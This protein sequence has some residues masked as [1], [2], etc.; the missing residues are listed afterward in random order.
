[1][2][3]PTRSTLTSVLRTGGAVAAVLVGALALSGCVGSADK[4]A[5]SSTPTSTKAGGA[6]QT[7]PTPT[8]TPTQ[9][10][11][12]VTL[13]CDQIVT[14]DQLYAFNP[15]FGATPDYKPKDGTLEKQ[16]ADWQ[17]ATCAW[18]NQTSGDV[19][20]IAVALPPSNALEG[21]KNGAVT[22]SQPVPT[23]GVPPEVEGYF[24]PGTAGEVQIFRGGYWIVATSAA[25]FEPG[26]AAP[27]ME[28]VLANV[29]QG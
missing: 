7:T 19:V 15:N 29:P 24:K 23:Y 27:L 2:V 20:E 14:P 1:M 22:T 17:G 11:T 26:D 8:P 5:S 12:P 28:N 3:E 10:P 16:I 18:T 6:A 4:P 9:P 13:T 21:L 25:F